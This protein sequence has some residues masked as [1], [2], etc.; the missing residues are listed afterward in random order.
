MPR[1]GHATITT[2]GEPNDLY[3]SLSQE[4]RDT[5]DFIGSLGYTPE[6]GAAGM[7]WARKSGSKHAATVGPIESLAA[8]LPAVKEEIRIDEE[9]LALRGGD[10]IDADPNSNVLDMRTSSAN[11]RVKQPYLPGAEDIEELDQQADICLTAQDEQQLAKSNF[12]VAKEEMKRRLKAHGRTN[13]KRGGWNMT[14]KNNEVLEL[15]QDKNRGVSDKPLET[16]PES[17]AAQVIDPQD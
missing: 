14:I 13:Y 11:G 8:L 1:N 10:A 3:D 12:T 2:K 16:D 17:E 6:Q 15:K 7:W 9:Q 5:W 4:A